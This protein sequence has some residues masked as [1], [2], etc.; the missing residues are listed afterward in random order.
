MGLNGELLIVGLQECGGGGILEF[1]NCSVI[2]QAPDMLNLYNIR[3]LKLNTLSK[4]WLHEGNDIVLLSLKTNSTEDVDFATDFINIYPNPASDNLVVS[5]KSADLP[6]DYKIINYFG[7]VVKS[8]VVA[9]STTHLDL[10]YLNSGV[11]FLNLSNSNEKAINRLF[12][13]E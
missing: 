2:T 13:K 6:L 10:S 4:I 5:V 12:V 3:E 11:Y 7:D 8:G 1:D 9:N